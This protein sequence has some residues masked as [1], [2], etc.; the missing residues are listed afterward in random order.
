MWAPHSFAFFANEGAPANE[1]KASSVP[2]PEP[3]DWAVLRGCV[4]HPAPLT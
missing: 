2:I 1:L 4:G 3:Q